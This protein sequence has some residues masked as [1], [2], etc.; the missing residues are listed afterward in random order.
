MKSTDRKLP[1]WLQIGSIVAVKSGDG[2]RARVSNVSEDADDAYV[3]TL[4]WEGGGVYGE[5]FYA[6]SDALFAFKPVQQEVR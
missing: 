1:G 4:R 2:L 3:I 6:L 5:T